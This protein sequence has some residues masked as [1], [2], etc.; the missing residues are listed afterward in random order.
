[1]PRISAGLLA[2]VGTAMSALAGLTHGDLVFV[3]ITCAG[4][5]AGL[6]AYL[7]VPKKKTSLNRHWGPFKGEVRRAPIGPGLRPGPC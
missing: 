5:A 6:A 4:T 1:M 2:A 3:M 7:A